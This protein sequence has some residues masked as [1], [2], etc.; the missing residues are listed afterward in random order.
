MLRLSILLLI[1]TAAFAED[2]KVEPI[3]I[4][5]V[6]RAKPVDFGTEIIPVFQKNCLACHNAKDAK[7]DL[8]LETPVTILKGGETGPA[9]APGKS[10]ESLL[11]KVASHQTKP[12]MPPKNNKA[13]AKPLTPDELGLVKLWIDQG[14]TG[15]VSVLPPLKWQNLADS[16]NPI[17]AS[18]IGPDG[19]F[20]ACSRA[21]H[22]DVYEIPTLQFATSLSDPSLGAADHDVVES[23][24]FSPDGQLLAAGSYRNVKI[25]K[26]QTPAPRTISNIPD[27]ANARLIAFSPEAKQIVLAT[28]NQQIRI[29]NVADG[30]LIHEF[31]PETNAIKQIALSASQIAIVL[32]QKQIQLRNLADTNT[33]S[34]QSPA[35]IHA[36]AFHLNNS[37]LEAG[38]DG[39]IRVWNSTNGQKLR[40]ISTPARMLAVSADG[41]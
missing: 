15:T 32:D 20:A 28:T 5:E 9:V 21:N 26:L 13:D 1:A 17:Q 30:K 11:L 39:V 24:T 7:G 4:A 25:W 29:L 33:I 14:A 6:K 36:L 35:E 40:D 37:L 34:I 23:L 41:K 8:V 18:A 22:I 16:F 2:S 12:F 19:Q 31:A 27:A 38:A 10:A 3:A